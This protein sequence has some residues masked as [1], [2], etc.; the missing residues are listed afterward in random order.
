MKLI[1]LKLDV[2]LHICG[3]ECH[4]SSNLYV[5]LNSQGDGVGKWT[6]GVMKQCTVRDINLIERLQG[7]AV[8][9][10]CLFLIQGQESLSCGWGRHS[11]FVSIVLGH[12]IKDGKK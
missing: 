12:R 11:A 5:K 9:S 2:F 6:W 8:S 4:V 7:D 1:N 3:L 10:L